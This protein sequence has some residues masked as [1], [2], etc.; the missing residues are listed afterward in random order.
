MGRFLKFN[1]VG[2]LFLPS[3]LTELRQFPLPGNGGFFLI[4]ISLDSIL[5]SLK[6][7]NWVITIVKNF[8]KFIWEYLHYIGACVAIYTDLISLLIILHYFG[9]YFTDNPGLEVLLLPF[10]DYCPPEDLGNFVGPVWLT[11]FIPRRNSGFG[12]I[13]RAFLIGFWGAG[14]YLGNIGP[15]FFYP[16]VCGP[17]FLLFPRGLILGFSPE[18]G[19][20]CGSA[21]SGGKKWFPLNLQGVLGYNIL[22]GIFLP[23]FK[24]GNKPLWGVLSVFKTPL[25]I[26]STQWADILQNSRG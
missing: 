24:I 2:R 13:Y 25:M 3:H 21:F 15:F 7:S 23:F 10:G 20:F 17:L 6:F 14:L 26:I 19:A 8:P 11:Y 5:N 4:K 12:F 22:W 16:G 1:L 18:S 9:K